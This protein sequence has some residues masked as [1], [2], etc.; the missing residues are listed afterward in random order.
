MNS[1]EPKSCMKFYYMLIIRYLAVCDVLSVR[2][3]RYKDK[4][5]DIFYNPL[6]MSRLASSILPVCMDA[7]Y[8]CV[9][10]S[11]SWPM[12]S[13]MTPTETSLS[14]AA[15]AHEWRAIYKAGIY[16]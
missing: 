6:R 8:I 2:V 13:L 3:R 11:E 12:A 9:V 10:F 16:E 7:R 15:V 5:P 1:C 14:L 4:F